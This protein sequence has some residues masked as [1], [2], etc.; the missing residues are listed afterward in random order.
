MLRGR[1][2]YR[3]ELA[4]LRLPCKEL[5]GHGY[6]LLLTSCSPSLFAFSV[7]LVRGKY[8][9]RLEICPFP[10]VLPRRVISRLVNSLPWY[11]TSHHAQQYLH[12]L[13]SHH[14]TPTPRFINAH[15]ILL[16]DRTHSHT[17]S[18]ELHSNASAEPESQPRRITYSPYSRE[19]TWRKRPE[20]TPS[21]FGFCCSSRCI[22]IH[23]S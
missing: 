23:L 19:A 18:Q 2:I 11:S 14:H 13:P 1:T 3:L 21:Y 16:R 22:F 4:L 7:P 8:V 9:I 6:V 5:P 15:S 12:K 17:S 20:L 10:L